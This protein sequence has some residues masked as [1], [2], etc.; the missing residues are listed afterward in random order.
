MQIRTTKPLLLTP[1]MRTTVLGAAAA[2]VTDLAPL[3]GTI[4]AQGAHLDHHKTFVV[5]YKLGEDVQLSRHFDNAEVTINVNLGLQFEEGEL[6][7]YDSADAP[8][9]AAFHEWVGSDGDDKVG[10][11]VLHL[12]A[13]HHAALP[14]SEGER[15]NLVMWMRSSRWRREEGCPM[16]GR[17]DQ[18]L[19]LAR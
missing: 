5:R 8:N 19:E 9:A 4:W 2:A 7:F 16:C 3:A 18:L 11:G 14:I 17:T 1:L 6:V 12:G 13:K 15:L 10:Q